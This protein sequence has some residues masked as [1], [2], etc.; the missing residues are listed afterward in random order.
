MYLRLQE[1]MQSQSKFAS[2]LWNGAWKELAGSSQENAN[3]VKVEEE[4]KQVQFCYYNTYH[5][6]IYLKLLSIEEGYHIYNRR[7]FLDYF[8]LFVN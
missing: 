8:K 5:R 6:D 7:M 2:E 4:I 1:E 3:A